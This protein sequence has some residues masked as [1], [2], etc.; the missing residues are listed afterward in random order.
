M[1]SHFFFAMDCLGCI[2][3]QQI[4]QKSRKMMAN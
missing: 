3:M 4:Y 1:F 2:N